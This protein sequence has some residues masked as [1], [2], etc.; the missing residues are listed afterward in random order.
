[1]KH[2]SK[3]P[4]QK[5]QQPVQAPSTAGP[6]SAKRAALLGICLLLSGGGTW[7]VMEFVVWNTT[8]PEL[9][10][11]WV[12]T[13]GPQEGATFDF[14]RNST[15]IG[16][17]NQDGKLGIVNARIH[18]EDD[19]IYATTKNPRTGQDTTL[20]QTIRTLTA[21]NLVIEDEQGNRTFMERAE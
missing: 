4:V 9:V 5:P 15:M 7:A 11:K 16:R 14:H 13:H 1:M 17:V 10:G 19:K 3:K 21:R 2:A 20:V 12:V 8:P 6:L 18:V